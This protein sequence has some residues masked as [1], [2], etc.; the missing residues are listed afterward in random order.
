[1]SL[2]DRETPCGNARSSSPATTRRPWRGRVVLVRVGR[3]VGKSIGMKWPLQHRGSSPSLRWRGFFGAAGALGAACALGV[4]FSVLVAGLAPSL[5]LDAAESRKMSAT[6]QLPIFKDP[7]A[8]LRAGLESYHSG[9]AKSSV[10]ALRYAADGG[11]QLA[12]WKLGR[13]YADGDGVARDDAKA[14]NYFSRIVEHFA[15]EEPDPSQR[16]LVASAFVQVGLYL[17]EGVPAAKISPDPERAFDLFRYAATYF[18]AAD[19]QYH[20]A[21][22]YLEGAGVKKDVRRGV[23]WLDLAARKGHAQAQATLGQLMFSG[24]VGGTA[25]RPRGLMYLTL[26]REAASGAEADQWIVDRHAKALSAASDADRSAAVAML[27]QY[28]RRRD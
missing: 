21:R 23:N 24:E 3:V 8:A 22:M 5:A 19:A 25:Q 27:E 2:N 6:A 11:E 4:A 20:L 1:M 9:N 10:E 15:D 7:Q 28:L 18:G 14:F 12:Q 26:A 17:R 13:M 16:S